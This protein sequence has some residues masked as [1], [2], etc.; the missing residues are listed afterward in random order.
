MNSL[1]I[2]GNEGHGVVVFEEINLIT[3][4][5]T[6]NGIKWSRIELGNCL[7]VKEGFQIGES[8]RDLLEAA[9]DS[10]E[11]LVLHGGCMVRLI[12]LMI[13]T[14]FIIIVFIYFS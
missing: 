11:S 5:S 13:Q 12:H 9:K 3:A 8:L 7:L 4:L 14:D 10:L 2:M 1:K 6:S